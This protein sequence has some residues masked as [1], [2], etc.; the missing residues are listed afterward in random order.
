[1]AFLGFRGPCS[2]AAGRF[3][4]FRVPGLRG[5]RRFRVPG[6]LRVD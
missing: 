5:F 1:M 4:G 2:W 3:R 6:L